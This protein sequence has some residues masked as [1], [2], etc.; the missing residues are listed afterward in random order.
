MYETLTDYSSPNRTKIS[1]MLASKYALKIVIFNNAQFTII[2]SVRKF[3]N[4]W[5]ITAIFYLHKLISVLKNH[6]WRYNNQRRT[7]IAVVKHLQKEHYKE[8]MTTQKRRS[9]DALFIFSRLD[10][11]STNHRIPCAK[12]CS[13]KNF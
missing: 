11:R 12:P 10:S 5:I 6:N 13:W 1:D 8:L 4:F 7:K 9:I 2:V 3:R